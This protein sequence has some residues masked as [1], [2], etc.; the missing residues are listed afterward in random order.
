MLT[1]PAWGRK[2]WAFESAGIEEGDCIAF[3]G[4]IQEY[5]KGFHGEDIERRMEN[6]PQIDY[7]IANPRCVKILA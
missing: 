1:A 7:S 2:P 4:S 3:T 6:P 5:V